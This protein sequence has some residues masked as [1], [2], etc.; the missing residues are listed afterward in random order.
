ML[1]EFCNALLKQRFVL[2]P[3]PEI[4]DAFNYGVGIQGLLYFF[5]VRTRLFEK[6]RDDDRVHGDSR[7][8]AGRLCERYGYLNQGLGFT[9]DM[10]CESFE[11]VGAVWK[12]CKEVAEKC[13]QSLEQELACCTEEGGPAALPCWMPSALRKQ[14]GACFAGDAEC[15]NRV[16]LYRSILGRSLKFLKD[17]YSMR[18][19]S[20]SGESENGGDEAGVKSLRSVAFMWGYHLQEKRVFFGGGRGRGRGSVQR[21]NYG[22]ALMWEEGELEMR[23]M[24]QY[25]GGEE[26]KKE[27]TGVQWEILQ[28]MQ[29]AVDRKQ[30]CIAAAETRKDEDSDYGWLLRQAPRWL[31]NQHSEL[32]LLQQRKIF[33]EEQMKLQ[34]RS[35]VCLEGVC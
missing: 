23:W 2:R 32:L 4:L 35:D 18:K 21:G 6:T 9:R 1:C 22:V 14:E 24:R 10:R 11:G 27:G 31:E 34:G 5:E 28:A 7:E 30:E 16:G 13:L 20:V 15:A 26:I 3:G 17:V 33:M 12:V 8:Q 25:L 19:E 29:E